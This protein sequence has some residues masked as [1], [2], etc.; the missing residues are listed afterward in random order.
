MLDSLRFGRHAEEEI[1]MHHRIG[2]LRIACALL[3]AAAASLA[4]S[5][6]GSSSPDANGLLKQTFTGSHTV[7]SGNVNISLTVTPSGSS[8]LSG[9][10]TL[11]FRGPF[12]SLGKGRLPASNFN[13]SV[14]AL[15]RSGSLGILS[16]GSSGYVTLQGTSYQLPP[17]TFQKLESSFA[18]ITSSSGGSSGTGALS[19]LGIDPLRWLVNPSVVGNES[20]G[21]ADT[22]NI[23]AGVNVAA[24]LEDLNTFLQKASSLGIS[25]ASRIPSNISATTRSRIASEVKSPTFEVWTGSSDKTVRRLAIRLTLPVSGQV[26]SLLGGLASAQIGLSMQYAN[27]NQPQ[28]IKAPTTVRPYSEF[29][30]KLQ[31]F[32]GNVQGLGIGATGSPGSTGSTTGSTG[33]TAAPSTGTGANVQSY[34]QCIKAAGQDVVKMQRCASLLNSK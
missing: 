13:I 20:V 21:G 29:T 7:D 33:S 15:G 10:I 32:L 16:T 30:A 8:T 24:L 2:G 3:I 28:T 4:I 19:K 12:E 18:Q 25:G 34:S 17:A 27:L 1:S 6:C 11:S 23:R 9:P 31:T 26:S 5:A 22:T 14:S